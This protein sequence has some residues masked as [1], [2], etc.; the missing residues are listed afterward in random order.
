MVRSTE[1]IKTHFFSAIRA[2]TQ[3]ELMRAEELIENWYGLQRNLS[4]Q[5]ARDFI[6]E[7]LKQKVGLKTHSQ[8][9]V[10]A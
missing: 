8:F 2:F 7:H 1:A 3:L 4:L 5:V 9:S 10:N 6:L